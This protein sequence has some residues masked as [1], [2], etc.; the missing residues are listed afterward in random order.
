ML[1]LF[2]ASWVVIEICL[3][4]FLRPVLSCGV[5]L[6]IVIFVCQ[7]QLL[8]LLLWFGGVD[9]SVWLS[10]LG[11]IHGLLF[12]RGWIVDWDIGIGSILLVCGGQV[13][14]CWVESSRVWV[15]GWLLTR[16]LIAW[17][18]IHLLLLDYFLE[19]WRDI[20]GGEL[21]CIFNLLLL[22][23]KVFPFITNEMF[24]LFNFILHRSQLLIPVLDALRLLLHFLLFTNKFLRIDV[25]PDVL[26]FELVLSFPDLLIQLLH[27]LHLLRQLNLDLDLLSTL[28][29]YLLP[30]LTNP[31][32]FIL[33]LCPFATN[34]P[35]F[36]FNPLPLLFKLILFQG[37][38]LSLL[39]QLFWLLLQLLTL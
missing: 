23:S 8:N 37:Q 9:E 7:F 32:P 38:F 6:V 19:I 4:L 26:F 20:H 33:H 12:A 11:Q 30:L 2:K 28:P 21:S 15:P 34:R 31:L 25:H 22:L 35:H 17:D 16:L 10:V 13:R 29:L 24:L 27:M 18:V 5:S 36:T 14:S 1:S 3:R 39:F